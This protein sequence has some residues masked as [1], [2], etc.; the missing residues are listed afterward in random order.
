MPRGRVVRQDDITGEKANLSARK[1]VNA[2][3]Q[4][5]LTAEDGPLPCGAMPAIKAASE[6]GVKALMGALDDENKNIVKPKKPKKAAETVEVTPKTLLESFTQKQIEQCCP[7]FHANLHFHSSNHFDNL[8][9][10]QVTYFTLLIFF[11]HCLGLLGSKDLT[12]SDLALSCSCTDQHFSKPR[13][14]YLS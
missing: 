8:V 5:A 2:E 7:G 4:S 3:L 9:Q 1:K 6:A 14:F 11:G 13:T 12:K 10:Q